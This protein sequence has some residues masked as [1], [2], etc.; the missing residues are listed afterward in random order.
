VEGGDRP[1][2]GKAVVATNDVETDNV[3]LFFED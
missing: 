3:A 1:V 2:V